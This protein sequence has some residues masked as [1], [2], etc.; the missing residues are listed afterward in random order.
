MAKPYKYHEAVWRPLVNV[1]SY[2]DFK[3][4]KVVR[5]GDFGN[6]DTVLDDGEY[7]AITKPNEEKITWT[8]YTAGNTFAITRKMIINDDVPMVTRFPDK[9][10]HAAGRTVAQ[11]V[12]DLILNYSTAI[13]DGTIY[14]AKALYH[15]DHGNNFDDFALN[16][17]NLSTL[18]VRMMN[19]TSKDAG[20]ILGI[21]P[22]FLIVPPDLEDTARKLTGSLTTKGDTDESDFNVHAG[23]WTVVMAPYLRGDLNNWY[24]TADPMSGDFIDIGFFNGQD[25]PELLIANQPTVGTTFTHDRIT[26]K[27]RIEP[28]GA[29]NDYRGFAASLKS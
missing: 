20:E 3:E 29:I 4:N 27:V 7:T 12:F 18:R 25:T 13:N 8:G 26:Y 19:Q 15:A 14:D 9:L 6:L 22:K 24:I 16:S 5:M 2:T 17:D 1:I 21:M 23:R 11:F 10:G 28:G